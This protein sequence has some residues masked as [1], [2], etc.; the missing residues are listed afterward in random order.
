MRTFGLA[1]NALWAS[2]VPRA[3]ATMRVVAFFMTPSFGGVCAE[4]PEMEKTI[5]AAETV[6]KI[7]RHCARN[8]SRATSRRGRGVRPQ[9][10]GDLRRSQA[11]VHPSSQSQV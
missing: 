4:L 1:A 10:G 5:R 8:A 11:N 6:P 3:R 7:A 9:M 2:S